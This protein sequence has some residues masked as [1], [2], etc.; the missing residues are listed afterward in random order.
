MTKP[1][2]NRVRHGAT[3]EDGTWV[4]TSRE[5]QL[6]EPVQSMVP[7]PSP[8]RGRPTR[9]TEEIALSICAHL[10]QG[11]TLL[12]ICAADE[13]LP[14]HSTIRAWA[15]TD[16]KGFYSRYARAREIGLDAM[17]EQLFEIADDGRKDY[18]ERVVEGGR[19]IPVPDHEHI[20]RSKLRIEARKWYLSK[21]APK[22]Y[23]DRVEVQLSHPQSNLVGALLSEVCTPEELADL[24][25]RLLAHNA[26]RLT[27]SVATTPGV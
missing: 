17:A 9:Y 11:K 4:K 13:S 19:T 1:I 8:G 18:V 16:F 12:N 10:A 24:K 6:V 23:G 7:R 3:L 14:D 21:L 25:T 20:A 2:R 22:R 27:S 5:L 15:A 26:K